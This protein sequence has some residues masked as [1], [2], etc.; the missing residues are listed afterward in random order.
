[1]PRRDKASELPPEIKQQLHLRL[2]ASN[3]GDYTAHADWLAQQGFEVSKSALHRYAQQHEATIRGDVAAGEASQSELRMRCLEVTAS[4][5]GADECD[6]MR[7]AESLL[8]W[9]TTR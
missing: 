8:A 2:V 9:V 4:I 5:G 1:M 6:L 3:F 7:R